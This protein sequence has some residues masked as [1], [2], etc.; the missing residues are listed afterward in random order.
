MAAELIEDILAPI[1]RYLRADPILKDF[2]NLIPSDG[3]NPVLGPPK[4]KNDD[5]VLVSWDGSSDLWI[6]R[7]TRENG[8]PMVNVEGTGSCS[9]TIEYGT[10]WDTNRQGTTF[11]HPEIKVF[12]HCDPT[13]DREIGGPVAAD[14]RG[15][16]LSLHKRVSKLLSLADTGSASYLE[17]GKRTDGTG[18]L[19][20]ID[21]SLGRD[22]Y[23][24][25]IPNG[26]GM[27]VGQASFELTV[28]L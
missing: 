21:S 14:A 26:D 16:C 8:T 24:S 22:L 9:I 20:V 15:K 18:A 13:R 7:G 4:F 23:I 28:H 25:D 27:V 11:S 12:Y 6:F 10:P 3:Y 5:G 17:M 1:V 2:N 19:R